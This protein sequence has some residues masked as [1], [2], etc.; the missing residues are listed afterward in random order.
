MSAAVSRVSRIVVIGSINMDL[1]IRCET[2]ARPGETISGRSLEEIPGGKG[3]NQAVAAARLG[4]AVTLVGRVG[5]DAFGQLLRDGLEREGI[6]LRFVWTTA[7]TSS[8]VAVIQVDDGGQNSIVV[9]PGANAALT[10][11]DV[12]AAESAIAEA[13]AVLLQF[14]IPQETVAAAVLLA[15]RHS[16]RVI[17]DPAPAREDVDATVLSADWLLP[18]ETEAERL[19]GLPVQ[20]ADEACAA[21]VSLRQRGCLRSVITRGEHGVIMADADGELWCVEPYRVVTVDTTAAGDAFAAGLAIGL[22]QGKSDA[23]AVR[24]ACAAGA[25]AA[26][27]PGAQPAMPSMRDVELLMREQPESGRLSR[28]PV[29]PR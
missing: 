7:G 13:D 28:L 22:S 14:E 10:P 15:R 17:V 16:V 3:A 6:D 29:A 24:Y 20:T 19:T 8:G 26:A 12:W 2:I 4:A 18:N 27:R 11:E 1:V 5:D 25:T 9:I 21:A 23:D